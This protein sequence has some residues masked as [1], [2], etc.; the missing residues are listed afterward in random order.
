MKL[1]QA[2]VVIRP[3]SHWEAL[4]LGALLAAR[5]RRLLVA[6]WLCVTLPIFTVL[7]LLCWRSPTLAALLFW[8]GKPLYERVLLFILAQALFA[9]PPSLGQALRA[10]PGLLRRQW[11]ASL[12]WRR[13]SPSRSFDLPILQLEGLNGAARR[14]RLALLHLDHGRP[15][16][17]L[18][19]VGA[20]VETCL[21]FGLMGLV[22]AMAP[23]VEDQALHWAQWLLASPDSGLLWLGHLSNV[24]YVAVLAFW[25]PIYVACGFTLYLNRRTHLEAWDVEL[26][27]RA[28]RQRL[29]PVAVVGM[30][31]A[32]LLVPSPPAY[33][34]EAPRLAQQ[35]LN[36]AQAE[37]AIGEIVGQPPFKNIE[38]RSHWQWRQA[39]APTPVAPPTFGPAW[40]ALA[41]LLEVL[42]WVILAA[43]IGWLLWHYRRSLARLRP[44]LP[45]RPRRAQATPP[46]LFGLGLAAPLPADIAAEAQRLW[47]DDPRQALSLLYRGLLGRLLSDYKV[48]L[49]SADTEGEVLA[50][51]RAL[52]LSGLED[53]SRKLTGHWQAAAYGQRLPS[54]S[55]GEEL[56]QAWR[57]LFP[58]AG[59][60]P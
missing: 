9:A 38:Q 8:W 48:P 17:W 23:N 47:A 2:T 55:A 50:R 37:Q 4:D 19:L 39:D 30:L 42:G 51:V 25:E 57:R 58:A 18:T 56:C 49:R 29:A 1:D 12:T 15:A 34:A 52:Q 60:Q 26:I 31:L 24:F 13:L 41:K 3:R 59:G 22:V 16:A 10:W 32:C 21:L 45:G 14:A 53:F 28:L 54:A 36:A 44:H 5:H 27:L 40:Q 20:H 11:L 6:A 46:Q 35:R 43:A 33:A 7:S